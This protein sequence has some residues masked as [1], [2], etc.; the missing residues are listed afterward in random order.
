MPLSGV[1]NVFA[2]KEDLSVYFSAS[3]YDSCGS[4][5][6]STIQ[7]WKGVSIQISTLSE[8]DWTR[9][10]KL[11][12][13]MWCSGIYPNAALL[14]YPTKVYN[15]HSYA[16]Y[17]Q[18]TDNP[19]WINDPRGYYEG[20]DKCY[21]DITG[22]YTIQP[23][24]I[25]CYFDNTG[26]N[27]HSAVVYSVNGDVPNGSLSNLQYLTLVSKWGSLGL[28]R[29][30]GDQCPY[31]GATMAEVKYY[32]HFHEADSYTATGSLDY[33]LENCYCGHSE[34]AAHSWLPRINGFVCGSCGE[35]TTGIPVPFENLPAT[36]QSMATAL[37][38]G[39]SIRINDDMQ[40][41]YDG[42]NYYV[43]VPYG[44]DTTQPIVIP[45]VVA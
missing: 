15:C 16:W 7:T 37:E 38:D 3:S 8:N 11:S 44:T 10:E 21:T 19:Y 34:E 5:T 20:E 12:L 31:V 1:V 28:Y 6:V 27:K 13:V 32:R 2:D 30:R 41:Y 40:L 36:V 45:E 42:E 17:M 39:M 4:C 25:V 9:E 23:G 26:A 14:G 43:L 24:D 35:R 29:H 22:S 33:H 18:S